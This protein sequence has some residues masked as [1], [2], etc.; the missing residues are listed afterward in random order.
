NIVTMT[1][2]APE[3]RQ[4]KGPRYLAIAEALAED[5]GAGRLRPGAR[6]PT[7]RELAD[8]LGLTVGTVT[9]AYAEAARRNLISGEVGRGTVQHG[10]TAVLAALLGPGDLVLTEALTYPGMKNLA[11]LLSLRLEGVVLDEQGMRPDALAAACRARVAKAVY[12]VPTLQ[13]PTTSVMS[14][15]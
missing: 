12:C 3:I 9:R 6:L 1:S 14:E 11:G 7:H 4:R 13:N 8:H 5:A 10:M 2:W 15:E